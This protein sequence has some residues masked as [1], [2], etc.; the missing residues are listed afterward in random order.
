MTA[1]LFVAYLVVL[2][3]GYWLKFLNLVYLKQHA[4]LVPSEFE[5]IVNPGLL[6][7][8]S[9]YTLENS[10]VGL[11]ESVM[12]NI[13]ILLLVFGG[14]LGA[15]DNLIISM[16][17]SFI[18]RGVLFFLIILFIETLLGIPF[19]LYRNFKVESRYGFNTMPLRLWF[20]D[21]I[22]SLAISLI[23]GT[24]VIVCALSIVQ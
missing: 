3:I 12:G 9:Q 13:L 17:G 2:A 7:R 14:L 19:S 20:S 22:K 1:S 11:L 15:Y 24:I 8:I 18:G 16:T 4:K 6:E 5:G 10:R 21:F 23:L